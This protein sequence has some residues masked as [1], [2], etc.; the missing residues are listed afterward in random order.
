MSDLLTV[1]IFQ[2]AITFAA[3]LLFAGLGELL[4]ERVGVLNLAIEGMMTFAAAVGFLV[5]FF[6]GSIWLG[7]LAAMVATALLGTIMAYC[8]VNLRSNQLIVGLGVLVLGTGLSSLF[9]RL[10][11][12]VKLSV[13][14]IQL[15]ERAPVPLLNN[16][17]ILGPILFDQPFL[18]YI[19]YMLVPVLFILLYRT[20]IGLRIR[21]TGENMRAAD[22]LGIDVFKIR[23]IGTVIGSAIIGLGGAYLPMVLTG[24]YSEGMVSGRGWLA[25]LL[26]PFGRWTPNGVLL[27]ALFFAYLDAVQNRLAITTKVIPSQ[28]FLML[29][30]IAAIIVMVQIYRR[31]EAPGSLLKPY[32]REE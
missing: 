26:V 32:S 25:L 22:T 8:S 18:A 12:G 24:T 23:F 20:P 15:M 28:V 7:C 19:A 2:L 13:P 14:Q 10:F 27:G 29:P 16:I 9:Y 30:Y 31:A 11:V 3:P 1:G 5:T 17:P 21:A 4:I 6:S